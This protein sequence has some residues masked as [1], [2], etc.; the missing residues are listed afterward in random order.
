MDHAPSQT[1]EQWRRVQFIMFSSISRSFLRRR[2]TK[3]DN[4][5]GWEPWPD[6]LPQD[7]PLVKDLT[8]T[9]SMPNGRY[10][11]S[12]YLYQ[13]TFLDR[14]ISWCLRFIESRCNA[15]WGSIQKASQE[16]VRGRNDSMSV[17]LQITQGDIAFPK[18]FHFAAQRIAHARCN[19]CVTFRRSLKILSDR[20]FAVL[21]RENL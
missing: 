6:L 18:K 16:P 10:M 3:V 17:I 1:Y 2:G 8:R 14:Y 15:L 20:G 9:G 19:N 13:F 21:G 11:K 7:P 4:Q 12:E 5:T